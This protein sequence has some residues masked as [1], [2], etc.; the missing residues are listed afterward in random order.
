MGVRVSR[1]GLLWPIY[2]GDRQIRSLSFHRFSPDQI[3][4]TFTVYQKAIEKRG[5]RSEIV[6]E[7]GT[8]KSGKSTDSPVDDRDRRTAQVPLTVVGDATEWT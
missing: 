7:T 3:S 6:F 2:T 5:P 8:A 4:T 1:D